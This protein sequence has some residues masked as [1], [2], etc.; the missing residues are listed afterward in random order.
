MQKQWKASE[1]V[2]IGKRF[3]AANTPPSV[4]AH[5][6]LHGSSTEEESRIHYDVDLYFLFNDRR[7]ALEV[8]GYVNSFTREVCQRTG[9]WSDPMVG[10]ID[11]KIWQI[12]PFSLDTIK[13]RHS[14]IHGT[15]GTLQA[16]LGTMNENFHGICRE[17]YLLSEIES[18][19]IKIRKGLAMLNDLQPLHS[20]PVFELGCVRIGS[21]PEMKALFFAKHILTGC[22]FA[23]NL[24]GYLGE[25]PN[26]ARC[27]KR[28]APD[29]IAGAF[30]F[31]AKIPLRAKGIYYEGR[32]GEVLEF[33]GAC[34]I[35]WLEQLE[36]IKNYLR[37]HVY[38]RALDRL[39]RD[40]ELFS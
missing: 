13:E 21:T 2:E 30:Q 40:P 16:A 3:V 7:M 8:M 33:L 22:A 25:N 23:V 29:S 31:P 34:Q 17:E 28:N 18:S 9:L 4:L 36:G 32:T 24:L 1:F 15:E 37:P 5:M 27:S 6:G 14:I 26:L 20:S 11:Q 19:G 39:R 38:N 35:E 12:N 10:C